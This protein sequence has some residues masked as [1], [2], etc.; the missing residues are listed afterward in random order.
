MSYRSSSGNRIG[1]SN[2]RFGRVISTSSPYPMATPHHSR[3]NTR[4]YVG[5]LSFRTSWQGLKD[6]FKSVSPSVVRAEILE[7]EDGRSKGCGIVQFST[8]REASAAI[9][10]L[11]DTELDGRR[12]FVR[13]DR[14][15]SVSAPPLFLPPKPAG[16]PMRDQGGRVMGTKRVYVGNLAWSVD[17]RAL[18]DHLRQC[19]DVIHVDIP[20]EGDR[21]KGYA[22]AEFSTA[23]GAASC[24]LMLNDSELGGRKIFIREDREPPSVTSS[25]PAYYPSST[26]HTIQSSISSEKRLFVN[27]LSWDVSWQ[28]LKD[29]FRTCGEV[30][31]RISCLFLPLWFTHVLCTVGGSC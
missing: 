3:G 23:L 25:E 27:N 30:F 4:V 5:N 2:K 15:A 22:L 17:W 14:E 28:D 1:L 26:A 31:K 10:A 29:H 13:E 6:H 20:M 11:H 16:F 19:G 12:I 24:I 8:S 7:D 18:K 9:K 21:S